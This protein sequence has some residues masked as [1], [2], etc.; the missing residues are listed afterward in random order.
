MVTRMEPHGK[1][2][3]KIGVPVDLATGIWILTMGGA[4]AMQHEDDVGSIEAGKLAD[5]IVLDLNLFDEVERGRPDLISDVHVLKTVFE[6]R[7]VY[8]A[9]KPAK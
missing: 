2:P 6:G 4:R 3:G 8:D 9:D 5:M 7:I 1:L